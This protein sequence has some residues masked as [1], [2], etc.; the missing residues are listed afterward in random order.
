VPANSDEVY[1]VAPPS[2]AIDN[3]K[4]HKAA[5]PDPSM[6][7]FAW[8]RDKLNDEINTGLEHASYTFDVPMY[9]RRIMRVEIR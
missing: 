4:S 6:R 2:I 8:R 7:M 9:D 5:L 3:P 1:P